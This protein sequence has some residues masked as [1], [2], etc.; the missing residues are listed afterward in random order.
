MSNSEDTTQPIHTADYADPARTKTDL[1]ALI[2]DA[3]RE[4]VSADILPRLT[5]LEARMDRLEGEMREVR[6]AVN[7]LEQRMTVLETTFRHHQRDVVLRLTDLEDRVGD[8]P[9]KPAA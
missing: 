4:V 9:T 2:V 1:R 5:A 3:V 8:M 7:R 6:A